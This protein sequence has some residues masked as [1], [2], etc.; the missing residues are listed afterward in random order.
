MKSSNSY[1]ACDVKE[2]PVQKQDQAY[3]KVFEPT[4]FEQ[5]STHVVGESASLNNLNSWA[6]LDAPICPSTYD[7]I[8]FSPP[9]GGQRQVYTEIASQ[10]ASLGFLVVT[11]D[12]PSISGAVEMSDGSLLYNV[13]GDVIDYRETQ[14]IQTANLRTIVSILTADESS[15]HSPLWIQTAVVNANTSCILGHGL[16]GEA[17][18]LMVANGMT[19]CGM[20]LDNRMPMPGPFSEKNT[21]DS[22]KSSPDSPDFAPDEDAVDL[23]TVH[24]YPQEIID[25]GLPKSPVL[26]KM[27]GIAR[28][29]VSFAL[30]GIVK[31][32]RYIVIPDDSH[33][34]TFEKRSLPDEIWTDDSELTSYQKHQGHECESPYDDDCY[35]HSCHDDWDCK[36]PEPTPAPPI[37]PPPG[38]FPPGVVPPPPPSPPGN[39]NTNDGTPPGQF[40]SYP[41]H[42]CGSNC[43]HHEEPKPCGPEKPGPCCHPPHG[44]VHKPCP[45]KDHDEHWEYD[46]DNC[47][48]DKHAGKDF[49]ENEDG[50]ADS[51]HE[52]T[53]ENGE[54]EDDGDDYGEEE[55][56]LEDDAVEDG[57]YENDDEEDL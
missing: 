24:P 42:D 52:E 48:T 1:P 56:E 47:D 14:L 16:G 40:P 22:S 50:E 33:D 38:V 54:D 46:W 39:N 44:H 21:P 5:I 45:D 49:Q 30:E 28:G 10:I 35:E 41:P 9:V 31:L 12:H 17:S 53:V 29:A 27:V 51:N 32:F 4:L 37:W 55:D 8:M 36:R 2:Q 34:D 6:L 25:Q 18:M 43:H 11:V 23:S 20:V 3:A 7:L 57:V 26:R 19:S 15:V 13:A